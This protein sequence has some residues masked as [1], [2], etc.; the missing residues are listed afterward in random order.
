MNSDRLTELKQRVDRA[1]VLAGEIALLAEAD[2]YRSGARCMFQDSRTGNHY[3][4]GELLKLV[5]AEG[6]SR[7]MAGRELELESLVG[8]VAE[9]PTAG[10]GIIQTIN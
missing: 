1:Q 8:G 2:P 10:M 3:L 5:V 7:I 6:R 9:R 4:E